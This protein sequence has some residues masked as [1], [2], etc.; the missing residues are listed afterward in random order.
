[1][2][3]PYFDVE[4]LSE[5]RKLAFFFMVAISSSGTHHVAELFPQAVE[6]TWVLAIQLVKK[7][8][9]VV[10]LGFSVQV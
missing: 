4:R 5:H 2:Q 6:K 8:P 3:F 9:F 1:V 10:L 7:L